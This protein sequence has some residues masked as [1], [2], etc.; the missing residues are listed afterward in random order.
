MHLDLVVRLAA[1]G[2]DPDEAFC[3]ECAAPLASLM[4]GD[5]CDV[6]IDI[7]QDD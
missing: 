2:A 7:D 3:S 4:N 5:L 6:C 1:A